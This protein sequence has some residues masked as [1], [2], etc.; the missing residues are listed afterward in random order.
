MSVFAT[1]KWDTGD[2]AS[3]RPDWDAEKVED[4]ASYASGG[5]VDGSVEQGWVI[6]ETLLEMFEMPSK[7]ENERLRKM[8][9]SCI[10]NRFSGKG[11]R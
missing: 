7:I 5:L 4:A 10:P 11:E 6:L 1:I 3:V 8:R 2:I 9:Q